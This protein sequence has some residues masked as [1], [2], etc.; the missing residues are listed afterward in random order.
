MT[1]DFI[2]VRKVSYTLKMCDHT[3]VYVLNDPKP[4]PW[5]FSVKVLAIQQDSRARY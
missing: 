3:M 1:K 5:N 2:V 4:Y